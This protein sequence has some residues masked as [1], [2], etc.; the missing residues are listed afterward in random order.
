LPLLAQAARLQPGGGHL[1]R[2][3]ALLTNW[4]V[5]NPPFHG[6]NWAC[7]QEAALRALH[8]GLALALLGAERDLQAGARALL[9]LHGRTMDATVAAG[10]VRGQGGTPRDRVFDVV[11]RRIDAMQPHRAGVVRL[12]EELRSEPGVAL[13]LLAQTPRSAARLLDAAEVDSG[14]VLGALR[15]QGATGVW[16]ATLRAWVADDSADLG[17]TMAAL[18]RALDRA[19]QIARSLRLDPGDMA[20]S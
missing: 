16:L 6:P 12:L 14:G 5:A 18:D 8:F 20:A 9:A 2:A 1:D 15:V 13:C 4:A 3:E 11:M 10:T 17:A 7:G 19:E